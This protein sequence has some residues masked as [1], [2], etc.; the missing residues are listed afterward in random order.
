MHIVPL[1]SGAF[2]KGNNQ[3]HSINALAMFVLSL[4]LLCGDAH[5]YTCLCSLVH[6]NNPLGS[7]TYTMTASQ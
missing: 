1:S 5:G 7:L 4:G 3:R 2:V 6:S